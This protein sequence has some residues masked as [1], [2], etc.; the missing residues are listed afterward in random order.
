[1]EPH[2]P[3]DWLT[4]SVASRIQNHTELLSPKPD[5]R[6]ENSWRIE[7]GTPR[8]NSCLCRALGPKTSATR[9]RAR[10]DS[11]YRKAPKDQIERGR[12][13]QLEQ[14]RFVAGLPTRGR[15]LPFSSHKTSYFFGLCVVFFGLWYTF[16]RAWDC[17]HLVWA[18]V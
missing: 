9:P 6:H 4:S 18:I 2:P 17:R 16:M 7:R 8:R 5:N 15:L 10:L 12:E 13:I 3:G 14:E 11:L 1:M